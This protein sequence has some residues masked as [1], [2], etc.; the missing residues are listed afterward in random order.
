MAIISMQN[1]GRRI[2]ASMARSLH[3][4][5]DNDAVR[6]VSSLPRVHVRLLHPT[7]IIDGSFESAEPIR[8]IMSLHPANAVSSFISGLSRIG[9]I[10]LKLNLGIPGPAEVHCIMIPPP[11]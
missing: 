9:D 4:V 11:A 10:E 6:P 1:D 8:D 2:A 3:K 7:D 5:A